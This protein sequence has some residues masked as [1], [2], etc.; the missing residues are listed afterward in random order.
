MPWLR[1]ARPR[2]DGEQTG[3]SVLLA[4]GAACGW[5]FSDFVRAS[6]SRRMSVLSILMGVQLCAMT[7]VGIAQALLGGPP[8]GTDLAWGALAGVGGVTGSS[9]LIFGYRVAPVGVV[10]PTS[11]VAAAGLPLLVS[12][13]RGYVPPV[14]SFTA[15]AVGLVAVWLLS[16]GRG[17]NSELLQDAPPPNLRWIG[18]WTG[19]GQSGVGDL[20]GAL[21]GLGSGTGYAL[22]YLSYDQASSAAGLWPVLGSQT[23][24]VTVALLLALARRQSLHVPASELRLVLA[25]GVATAAALTCFLLA[26][27]SGPVT[28]VAVLVSMSPAVTITLATALLKERTTA[29]QRLGFVLALAAA[30]ILA[31][32]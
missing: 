32:N 23:V 21:M 19:S 18:S 8:V 29:R 10:C 9:L 1:L 2:E 15:I 6:L 13:A 11:A 24:V 17:G 14:S 26:T 31:A 16:R 4:L 25:A 3:L 12:V 27:R 30:G 5:G 20:T 28:T 7:L 22:T